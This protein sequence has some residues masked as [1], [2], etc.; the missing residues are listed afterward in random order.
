LIK[1]VTLGPAGSNH[2]YVTRRYLAFHGIAEKS[3]IDF[4]SSFDDGA[5][6]VLAGAADFMIQCAVH[7]ATVA[8]VAKY[9]NGLFVVDTFISPSQDLAVIKR[10]DADNPRTLAAMSPTIDYTDASKWDNIQL[11]DTVAAVSKGL[12]DGTYAAGLGYVSFAE[13]Y[14]DV[15]SIVEFIGTVDD[16]WIVYGRTKV[17]DG[18]ISAWPDSPAAAIFHAMA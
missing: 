18:G 11:V 13:K 8:T 5:A 12:V 6:M 1:F 10:N 17:C 16:A 14:P 15:L 9:L 3:G 4:V 2:E 7:P